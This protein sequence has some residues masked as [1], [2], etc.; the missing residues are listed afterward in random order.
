MSTI[1]EVEDAILR[2]LDQISDL[3]PEVRKK[4]RFDKYM[5]IGRYADEQYPSVEEH[6]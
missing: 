3:D 6:R 2:H 1:R 4:Q 5:A